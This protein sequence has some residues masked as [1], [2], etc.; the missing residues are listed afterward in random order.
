MGEFPPLPSSPPD[1][2]NGPLPGA[3]NNRQING[4]KDCVN[5]TDSVKHGRSTQPDDRSRDNT[6]AGQFRNT[7]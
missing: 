5:T 7:H 1:Q 6:N 3:S 4:N 2:H